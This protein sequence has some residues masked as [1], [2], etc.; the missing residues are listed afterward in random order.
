MKTHLTWFRV[1]VAA[2]AAAGVSQQQAAAQYAPYQPVPQ[3]PAS[4]YP[5]AA[6]QPV[7][8]AAQRPYMA[9]HPQQQQQQPAMGQYPYQ[10]PAPQS[11][12]GPYAAQPYAA[13]PYA[14]YPAYPSVAQQPTPSTPQMDM[15]QQGA[16]SLP[17]PAGTTS[18]APNGAPVMPADASHGYPN[19]Y[20]QH[21]HNGGYPNTG[22]C[23]TY[24]GNAHNDYGL[25][26]YFNQPCNDTQW[27]GGVYGLYMERDNADFKRVLVQADPPSYPYYPPASTT[28]FSTDQADF[29][30]RE[31]IEVRFGSTFTVGGSSCDTG[32]GPYGYGNAGCNTCDTPQLFAWEVAFWGIDRDVKWFVITDDDI[33]DNNRL[34]GMI[35][36][37][38][39][40][41]DGGGGARPVN[42]YYDYQMPIEDTSTPVTGDIRVL[43]QRVRTNFRSYNVELNFLR[44]PVCDVATCA[45]ANCGYDA[46][47]G[48][49]HGYGA[50]C[51]PAACEPCGPAFSMA[52]LCGVRYFRM[53][54]GFELFTD[55][56]EYDGAA[57]MPVDDNFHDIQVEN[58]LVGFQLGANMNYC[59]AC[60]WNFFADTNFGLYNNHISHYQ[61]VY[62]ESGP[63]T[64]IEESRDATVRSSKD[65]IA[66]LGELRLGGSYDLTCNWRAVLAYRA[67]AISGVALATDQI[68]PEMSNWAETA[69]IDSNGSIIIHGVQAGVECRY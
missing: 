67:V 68:K 27:F 49:G 26:G 10:Q 66:F 57:W 62:G 50:A 34:Y 63:A 48:Y 21:S 59:V 23:N 42:D 65:D 47:G 18:V 3:A 6:H 12:Y 15:P 44:I 54:E 60:K 14:G 46:C 53:K 58:D 24:G 13:Q 30:F 20:S 4:Y 41:Y 29:E 2:C 38:G 37:A 51:A 5:P 33:T 35:N 19:G 9:Y 1:V 39:L 31:G 43:T 8:P 45:P 55:P 17:T 28:V 7:A 25:T 64:Y 56:Y 32:C 16:E 61:R 69:R 52:A 36:H 40:E 22:N 11:T